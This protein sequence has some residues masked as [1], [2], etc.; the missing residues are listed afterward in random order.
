MTKSRGKQTL[1]PYAIIALT[2][3]DSGPPNSSMNSPLATDGET[4]TISLQ[5]QPEQQAQAHES[6][7]GQR[8]ASQIID[9]YANDINEDDYEFEFEDEIWSR[10]QPMQFA[11]G[12]SEPWEEK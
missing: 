7:E 4:G 12:D 10:Q 6:T 5:R 9:E 11:R 2:S 3:R 8:R 1:T